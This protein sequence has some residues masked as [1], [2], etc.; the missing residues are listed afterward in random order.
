ML[1]NNAR[2]IMQVVL[3][4]TADGSLFLEDPAEA[5]ILLPLGTDTSIPNPR[6]AQEEGEIVEPE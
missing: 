5:D 3:E 1:K 6:V 4:A 2:E